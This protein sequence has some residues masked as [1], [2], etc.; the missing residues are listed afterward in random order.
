MSTTD[1][2][3]QLRT[4]DTALPSK[5]GNATYGPAR[6]NRYGEA[7]AWAKGRARWAHALEGT[8][9]YA[10]N[11]TNDASTTLAGHAAPVLADADATMTKPFVFIRNPS[12]TS[13][14]T[15]VVLDFIEITVVTAGA[16]GT[17]ASYAMQLDQGTTRWSSGGTA[18]TIVNPNMSNTN[19]SV[20]DETNALLGGAVVAGAENSTAR[21]LSFDD[22]RPSIEIAG[23]RKL[24]IFGGDPTDV[25]AS[26][27]AAV[28]TQVVNAPPVVLGPTDQFLLALYAPSQSAAGVYKLRM[29]WIEI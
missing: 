26:A 18:L 25:T 12:S 10:H 17:T 3:S 22:L 20:L 16:N 24:F 5:T 6:G 13:T 27:A 7:Y 11:A 21:H 4:Q 28:R 23:D 9:F 29:G 2:R 8:Y 19:D 14:D 15:R 1:Y